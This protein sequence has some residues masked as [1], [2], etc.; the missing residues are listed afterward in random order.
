M[1]FETLVF[2]ARTP[3]AMNLTLRNDDEKIPIDNVKTREIASAY[4]T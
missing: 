4:I 3:E 2:Y 1:Y